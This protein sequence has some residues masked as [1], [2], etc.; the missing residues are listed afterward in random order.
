MDTIFSGIKE[1]GSSF[2]EVDRAV[3]VHAAEGT[4]VLDILK[5]V[6]QTS[7]EVQD[8]SS[9][10]HEK[11]TF[12]YKEMNTLESISTELTKEVHEMRSAEEHVEKFLEKAKEIVSM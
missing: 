1:M 9:R 11:G 8:G 10:I 5:V 12:I 4:Q 2:G 6:Q 7:K 3:E